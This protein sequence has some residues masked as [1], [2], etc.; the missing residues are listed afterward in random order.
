MGKIRILS[1][2]TISKISA[3]EVVE[4]PASVVKELIENSLDAGSTL[5]KVDLVSGGKKI[6]RVEDN[7]EGMTRDD[8]LLS[9]ERHATS[10]IQAPQDIFSI[11]SLG[12]RGEALPSIAAVSQFTLITKARGETAGT[13][14]TVEGGRIKRVEDIGCP[15]GTMVE[16]RNLFFNTPPR[17]K[18]MRSIET[19]LRNS[20]DIIQRE[21]L[22]YP[23]VGF[24][25]IHAVKNLILLPARGAL[26][27]RLAE[28]FSDV[29]LFEIG[30]EAEGIRIH[31]FIAGPD[32]TRTTTDKLYTYVNRRPVRDRFIIRTVT[33]AYG[34]M[35]ERNKFPVGVILITFLN[36]GDVDINFH[37]TKNEVRFKRV[38][39]VRD[40]IGKAISEVLGNAPW[41]KDYRERVEH[42]LEEFYR[43][44]L[45]E[46]EKRYELPVSARVREKQMSSQTPPDL[47][48]QSFSTHTARTAHTAPSE[49]EPSPYELFTGRGFFSGL[50]IIGQIGELYI[51][52]ASPRGMILID[53]HAAHERI[54][55][56]GLKGS[57][58]KD[59]LEV[60]DLLLPI[61]IE[62]SSSEA[63]V[64]REYKE[65]LERLGIGIE[66]FGGKSFLIRSI[67]A[68]LRGTDAEG[69]LRDIIGEIAA[70]GQEKSLS[71][72]ID[73]VLSTMACHGSIRASKSLRK[74]EIRALL[75]QLDKADFPSSCPHGR[76]VAKELTFQE[77]D[78]MFKRT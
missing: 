60:Q 17:L 75:E 47:P 44:D 69:L 19:E 6:I 40:L 11:K 4:R 78:R 43:K 25:V 26:K 36:E 53:Q 31:G 1:D 51:V 54:T 20:L 12:F 77:L 67:P 13:K 46:K 49:P 72:C 29:E 74:D 45:K 10:K 71:E 2:E 38:G 66:E 24:E 37:P 30:A 73:E 7:G 57:Y 23:E 32:N 76:P 68:I 48:L 18:F 65:D 52:C 5:I 14:I 28:V 56:E 21:A 70:L 9:L 62:V 15:E 61:T 16:V 39:I 50:E 42:A 63:E 55:F 8:A 3:G 58:L 64:L 27:E 35:I 33:D 22:S 59:S 34:R 41:I